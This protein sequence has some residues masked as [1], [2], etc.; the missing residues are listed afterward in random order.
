[1]IGM[2]NKIVHDYSSVDVRIAWDTVN[3]DIQRVN[4]AIVKLVGEE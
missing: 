2:R 3:Q 4:K 1:M